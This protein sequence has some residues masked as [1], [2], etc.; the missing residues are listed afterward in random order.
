MRM[1]AHWIVIASNLSRVVDSAGRPIGIPGKSEER[2]RRLSSGADFDS[3]QQETAI[4][5]TTHLFSP[6][7]MRRTPH[8]RQNPVSRLFLCQ[9]RDLKDPETPTSVCGVFSSGDICSRTS[10]ICCRRR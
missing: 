6:K 2:D 10:I 7:P 5:I 3:Q 4:K 1:S 9:L 8:A